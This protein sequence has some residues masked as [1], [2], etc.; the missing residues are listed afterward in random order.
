MVEAGEPRLHQRHD[1]GAGIV[2]DKTIVVLL[3]HEEAGI[4]HAERIEDTRALMNASKLWPLT[5]STSREVTSVAS[6]YSQ[7]VPG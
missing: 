5:T 4:D 6:E 1:I 7:D 2:G 3:G